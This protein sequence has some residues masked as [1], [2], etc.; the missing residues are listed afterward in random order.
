MTVCCSLVGDCQRFEGTYC[1]HL[2]GL[3][4]LGCFF[5][6]PLNAELNPICHLLAILAHHIL[7]IGRVRVNVVTHLSYHG[8]VISAKP[9][10][11]CLIFVREFTACFR[12][13]RNRRNASVY[14]LAYNKHWLLTGWRD[15]LYGGLGNPLLNCYLYK[16]LFHNPSRIGFLNK[17]RPFLLFY[18]ASAGLFMSRLGVST[19]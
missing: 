12:G 18:I 4:W 1:F 17:Q 10:L 5:L 6:N 19:C 15:A 2:L 3:M 9:S 13:C 16:L 14:N 8:I 11:R 7:H